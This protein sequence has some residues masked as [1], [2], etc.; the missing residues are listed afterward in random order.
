MINI[1]RLQTFFIALTI[2]LSVNGC[3][4]LGVPWQL[5]A[6]TTIGDIATLNN[7]GKTMNETAASIALQRD[8]QWSR[9]FLGWPPCLT[10][11][12]WIDM[13]VAMNCETYS[14]NFLNNP[15]CREND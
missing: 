15:Y 5:S 1:T 13:L 10:R 6:V 2:T 4:F 14:W 11:A 9:V 3:A 7:H 8:C 12:E